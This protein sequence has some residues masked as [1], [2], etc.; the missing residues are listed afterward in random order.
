MKT[1]FL[2][3]QKGDL[4]QRYR[5]VSDTELDTLGECLNIMTE[6]LDDQIKKEYIMTI[7]QKK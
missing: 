2:K 4:S 3:I 7:E 5:F 1:L 6:R